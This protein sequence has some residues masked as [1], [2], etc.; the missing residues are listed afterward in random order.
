V[1]AVRRTGRVIRRL[2]TSTAT[3]PA[4]D[5]V[6]AGVVIVRHRT[7]IPKAPVEGVEQETPG[8]ANTV[9]AAAP[10]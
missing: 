4:T 8:L 1:S 7:I 3:A 5:A 2:Q 9:I 6:R 10:A